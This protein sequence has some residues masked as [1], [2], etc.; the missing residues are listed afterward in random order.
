MHMMMAGHYEKNGDLG[1]AEEF[2]KK[3]IKES[4]SAEAHERLGLICRDRY[5]IDGARIHFESALKIDPASKVSLYNMAI[6]ERLCGDYDASMKNYIRLMGMGVDDAGVYMSMGVL[7]SEMGDIQAAQKF[8]K[9]AFKRNPKNDLVRFN[10]SLCLMTLGDLNQG[11]ELYESRIW[12]AKPPG[13]EWRGEEGVNLLVSPEQGNGDIIQFARYLP[14]LRGRVN[15][16]TVLCNAPL[17]EMI[18]GVE[19]VDEVMEF[20]PGDEFVEVKDG[21]DNSEENLSESLPFHKYVRIMSIPHVLGLNPSEIKFSRYLNSDLKKVH[22]WS[23]RMRSEKLKVGLCWQGGK[24]DRPDMIAIDK[25]RSIKLKDMEP[26]LSIE[27]AQFFSLQKGDDQGSD[28][29]QITDFM[30]ESN[31]FSETAAMI[32]NLDLVISVDTA[33][34]HLSAALEKPTWMFARKGGCWRW[35]FEGESTFW[36]PSMR[37]Y[38]QEEIG[39]WGKTIEKLARDL[40]KFVQ[41]QK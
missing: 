18:K 40:F 33:V 16:V 32:E 14:L 37:I 19:G 13:E 31:D 2:Y 21:Q 4:P 5:E 35:G 8:Y 22:R 29:V 3:A 7:Y 9:E 34:A 23:K 28:F 39:M 10:Y 1:K 36:Y 12:H 41:E 27:G 15:K 26:I 38:R 6:I 11:L 30:D 24:R 25:R 20:N 17:V